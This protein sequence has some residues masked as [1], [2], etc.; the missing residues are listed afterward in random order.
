VISTSQVLSSVS[1]ASQATP[2]RNPSRSTA[3]D[4]T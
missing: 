4:L 3:Q 2:E 1:R